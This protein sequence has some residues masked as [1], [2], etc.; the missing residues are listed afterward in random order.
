MY[1]NALQI[2]IPADNDG[3]IDTDIKLYIRG[4]LISVSG[5]DVDLT[6]ATGVTNNVLHS[7]FSQCNITLKGVTIRQAS[8][9]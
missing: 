8:E 5:K 6:D 3:Y 4:K 7:L 9:H 2:V 1:Q